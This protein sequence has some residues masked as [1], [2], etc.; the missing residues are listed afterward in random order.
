MLA[1]ARDDV[2]GVAGGGPDPNLEVNCCRRSIEK[3]DAI[4]LRC[5]GVA[6]YLLQQIHVFGVQV[7]P[8]FVGEIAIG[9]LGGKSAQHGTSAQCACFYYW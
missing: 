4:E 7:P 3:L 2:N 1:V 5:H 6:V 8:I 9:R